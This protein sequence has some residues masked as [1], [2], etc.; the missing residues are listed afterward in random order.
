MEKL[1]FGEV[2][3]IDNGKEYIVFQTLEKD[4]KDYVYLVSNFK[5]LE[6][7]F[8]VQEIVD[9]EFLLRVD[10]SQEEK[11]QLLEEFQTKAR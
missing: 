9:G 7:K 10:E 11:E 3:V 1:E 5:P 4:G 6:V 8:A 2:A